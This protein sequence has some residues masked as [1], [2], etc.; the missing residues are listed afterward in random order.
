[1]GR[2]GGQEPSLLLLLPGTWLSGT[3]ENL[4]D[5]AHEWFSGPLDEQSLPQALRESIIRANGGLGH[6]VIRLARAAQLT[7]TRTIGNFGTA[8][9]V[10]LLTLA[11]G[12][13]REHV[14]NA[15][16]A[17]DLRVT[18]S[19]DSP[20]EAAVT[21]GMTHSGMTVA[22]SSVERV[23][24]V[25]I[26]R[27]FID[28]IHDSRAVGFYQVRMAVS[29]E[30]NEIWFGDTAATTTVG[31]LFGVPIRVPGLGRQP[32]AEGRIWIRGSQPTRRRDLVEV[33][34]RNGLNHVPARSFDRN[35]PTG[36]D[37]AGRAACVQWGEPLAVFCINHMAVR[38]D[39][40]RRRDREGESWKE[41]LDQESLTSFWSHYLRLR[42]SAKQRS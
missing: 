23:R 40:P 30:V 19:R 39:Q 12:F 35:E 17:T 6:R 34:G 7:M 16:D 37:D 36:M 29:P 20:P 5:H 3:G 26:F 21:G 8:A 14:L 11:T 31:A 10:V 38:S 27:V 18:F 33:M 28:A 32:G 13:R 2:A 4:D 1:V 9:L 42:A 25:L 15:R 24:H 22:G 41:I